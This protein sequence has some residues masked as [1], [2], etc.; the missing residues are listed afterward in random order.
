MAE[1][2]SGLRIEVV[3]VSRVV[4]FDHSALAFWRAPYWGHW[5]GIGG[6]ATLDSN[7][8]LALNVIYNINSGHGLLGGLSVEP[9]GRI[10]IVKAGIHFRNN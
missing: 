1:G 10:S 3:G 7:S 5:G 4:T 2:G 8:V 6:G 9:C